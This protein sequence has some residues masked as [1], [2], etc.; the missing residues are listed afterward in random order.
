M[1]CIASFKPFSVALVKTFILKMK[2]KKHIFKL[3]IQKSKQNSGTSCFGIVK[4]F[5]SITPEHH[6]LVLLKHLCQVLVI[7]VFAIYSMQAGY[8]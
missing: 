3:K 6:V 8:N 1:L 5:V 2:W 4:A 7:W